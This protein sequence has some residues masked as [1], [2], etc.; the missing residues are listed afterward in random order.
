[1][2]TGRVV[3]VDVV[4]AVVVVVLRLLG[5]LSGSRCS[6]CMWVGRREADVQ[7]PETKYSLHGGREWELVGCRHRHA[8][9]T[10]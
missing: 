7:K 9:G 6:W 5:R 2:V 4:V 1:M 8:F 3:V 10:P